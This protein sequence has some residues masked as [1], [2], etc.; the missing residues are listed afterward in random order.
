MLHS[1]YLREGVCVEIPELTGYVPKGG[2][3]FNVM[4]V[5][6]GGMGI[7]V[8]LRH[9]N[10]GTEYALKG[11]RPDHIDSQATVDRFLDELQVWLSASACNLVAEAIAV[12]KVNEAPCVLAK[13]MPNGDLAHAL[14]KLDKAA[15]IETLLRLVR[16]LSWVKNTLGV[17]H[18]DLKPPNILLDREGLAYVA[19]WGLARPIGLEMQRVR[20]SLNGQSVDRPD[21]TQVGSFLGT[22]TYAAPEQ[23]IGSA[24]IDHRADIYALGCM[25]YEFETGNPPFLGKTVN[26]IARKH[27]VE[28]PKKL[29]GLF[30]KTDLGLERVIARCLEKKPQDRFSIYEEL[31]GALLEIAS[32]HGARLSRCA[33]GLR[34]ERTVLGKGR[35]KQDEIIQQEDAKAVGDFILVNAETVDPFLEEASNLMAMSRYAEAEAL[36]RPYVHVFKT[37]PGVSWLP[38]HSTTLN[39]AVCLLGIGRLSDAMQFLRRLESVGGKPAEFYVNMSLAQL[40]SKM[41]SEASNTCSQGLSEF[42]NDPDIQGNLTIALASSG[43]PDAAAE[44]AV[45]RIKIRRDIHA[46][47]EGAAV[48]QRQAIAIRDIDLPRAINIAKIVGDLLNEGIELNPRHYPLRINQIV[49]RR[50]ACDESMVLT[51]CQELFD[52]DDCPPIFRQLAFAEMVEKLSE[53]KSYQ[54][55]LDLIQR[56]KQGDTDRLIAVRMRTLARHRMMGKETQDGKRALIPEVRDYFLTTSDAGLYRDPVMAAEILEWMEDSKSAMQTLDRYLSENPNDWEGI[57]LLAMIYVRQGYYNRAV[58]IAQ[59]LP[60]R[61]PWRAESYDV[62]S[63]VSGKAGRQDVADSAKKK[64]DEIFAKEDALYVGLRAHLDSTFDGSSLRQ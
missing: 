54:S 7:C 57:K 28:P 29:G 45:K 35:L 33:L 19:D 15:K 23:I 49:L 8:H 26:E 44:S 13:W 50:F 34:Y 24:H 2:S 52:S 48:L 58:A 17:I 62:L 39:Y 61:A 10:S 32:R 64:G 59:L 18:R 40:R 60:K 6:A 63:Y 5:F 56:S 38:P 43:D 3:T 30:K 53:G 21:R 4:G 47:E 20:E 55:A 22:V 27:I 1:Q 41:W 42:P 36:L 25:M 12:V 31:E 11:V 16:G 14:P 46:I 9:V 37:S 51:L